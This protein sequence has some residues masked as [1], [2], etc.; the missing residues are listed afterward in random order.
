MRCDR[1]RTRVNSEAVEEILARQNDA[2]LAGRAPYSGEK[3]KLEICGLGQRE[4][5]YR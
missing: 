2:L 3:T 4:D 1:T 5:S